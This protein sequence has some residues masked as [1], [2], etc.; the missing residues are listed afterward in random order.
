M[1]LSIL[2][3]FV[4]II[5]VLLG[6]YLSSLVIGSNKNIKEYLVQIFI[7]M[8][9]FNVL[10]MNLISTNEWIII[11]IYFIVS[12]IS[13]VFSKFLVFLIFKKFVPVVFKNKKFNSSLIKL[14]KSLNHDF[15]KDKT[16]SFFKKAGFDSGFIE[17]LNSIFKE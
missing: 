11:L 3:G 12:F 13:I 9:V 10:L 14:A 17:F 1:I 4:T 8:I 2:S 15:G 16:V 5:G 7:F 6:E